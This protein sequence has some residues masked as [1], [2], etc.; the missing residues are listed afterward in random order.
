M[1][2]KIGIT[3]LLFVLGISPAWTQYGV[4][5]FLQDTNGLPIPFANIVIKKSK[6]LDFVVGGISD[7][8]GFFFLE[9]NQEGAFLVDISV[10][11]FK[12]YQSNVFVINEQDSMKE[13]GLIM[14]NETVEQ[15]S[16][17]TITGSIPLF[18]R[19]IDRMVVN[20]S[21]RINTAGSSVLEILEK[22]PGVFVNRQST[23]I[24]MLG[25]DG[26]NIMINGKLQYMTADV[27][28]NY[29]QGLDAN[30]IKSIEL[31]TNPPANLD[32]QGNAGFI[33]LVLKKQLHEGL[34]GSYSLSAGYGSG[35]TGNSS[36]NLNYQEKRV[37]LFASYSYFRNG[38]TQLTRQLRRTKNLFV[39]VDLIGEDLIETLFRSD[40]NPTQN[41]HNFRLGLD[42]ELDKN[43]N[44]GVLFM[45]YSSNWDMEALNTTEIQS[46]LAVDT[47][48]T[49]KNIEVNDWRHLQSNINLTHIFRNGALLNLDFD[50]LVYNHRNPISYQ[51]QSEGTDGTL[52]DQS[53]LQ[54]KKNTPFDILVSKADYSVAL[55]ENIKLSLGA[56]YTT[57]DFE[58][59]VLLTDD[60][61]VLPNFTSASN[62]T[63]N[64]FALFSQIDYELS[65][66]TTLKGGLRFEKTGTELNSTVVGEKVNRSLNN[67]FP[68]IFWN[69]KVNEFNSFNLSYSRRINRP[70]FSDMAPFI[71]FLD[72]RTS[73]G[74]NASLR[75]ALANVFELSWSQKRVNL[76][77]QYSDEDYTIVKFQNRFN[78]ETNTQMIVPDNLE[79]QKIASLNMS[80]PIKVSSWWKMRIF[81]TFLW[82][83]STTIE[84]LGRFT[85][86]QRNFSINST[87]TIKPGQDWSLEF[88]GFYRTS[89]LA[90]NVKAQPTGI[91][92]LGIQ[93]KL[94][95]GSRLT[96]NFNDLFNSLELKGITNI[97]EENLFI[98]RKFDFSHRTIKLTYTATFGNKELKKQR[99]RQTG[100]DEEKSRIN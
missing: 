20:I 97:S 68:S 14:L 63:E 53:K 27:L 28:F 48:V 40:R 18:E 98:E 25:K 9:I 85:F 45:G 34:N 72:P 84:E 23:S 99:E 61:A 94:K 29:L 87:Q 62:L 55:N 77:A 92:N 54:S 39:D 80:F 79:S 89:S 3:M 81:S 19:K 24:G 16:G 66:K 78:P 6:N 95:K 88:S 86:N 50:Y 30:N 10:L 100:A 41:N 32:A 60:G 31:I 58:N 57:S 91:L 73:F 44:I 96:L 1:N 38:Q 46:S 76:T 36:I 11:G 69:Q 21:N 22:S 26:V 17:V 33:N 2:R 74:G 90:G 49:S 82:Q 42:L 65:Q 59:D 67:F 5:G 12:E 75:P 47:L 35:E 56:K 43:T 52:F 7:E 51:L 71:I 37:N 64:I 83:E 13:F 70:S 4:K 8:E 15:L 93:K